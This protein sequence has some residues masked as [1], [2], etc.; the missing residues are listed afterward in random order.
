MAIFDTVSVISS[1]RSEKVGLLYAF[2]ASGSIAGCQ[3][4]TAV[5]ECTGTTRIADPVLWPVVLPQGVLSPRTAIKVSPN[6]RFLLNAPQTSLLFGAAEVLVA[7]KHLIG[8][9]AVQLDPQ[10]K[11]LT[12]YHLLLDAHTILMAEGIWTESLFLGDAT[13]E[14]QEFLTLWDAMPALI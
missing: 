10:G 3:T 4:A 8:D 12:Y 1:H 2:G 6:H 11:P 5:V 7:A 13:L 14:H 9:G